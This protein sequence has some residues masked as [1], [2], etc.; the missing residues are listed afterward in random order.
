MRVHAEGMADEVK[1]AM[2]EFISGRKLA[3]LAAGDARN[4]PNRC[5]SKTPMRD[6][7]A[8]PVWNGWSPD[9]TN[10]RFHRAS[11]LS[12]SDV[13]RLT[14]KW[15]FGFPGVSSVYGQPTV[16]GGRV[17]VGV[18]T[19]Y[20]YALDAASGCVHWSFLA[21]T[22]VRNAINI[23][24]ASVA[25][26]AG[27]AGGAPAGR[28]AA[29]FGDIRGN[30]Y[31]VDAN[32][33]ELLWKVN[34]DPHPLAAITGSPTLYEGRLYV[35]VSS[36]EEAAG[37]SLNYPCCTFRGSIVALDAAT[38]RQL[39]KTYAIADP[40]K[41]SRRNS[42]GTQLWTGAGA[43]IWHAPTIDPRNRAIYV[44]TGDAY[45]E[46]AP[47]TTDAVMAIH[48]DT[49]AVLWSVQD[50][51]NDAWLVACA[52]DPTENCPKN[53]GPDYDFGASPILKTLPD[54]KRAL[55]AGQK[56]G[57]VFA[58][59]PDDRGKLLWKAALVE[60]IG[61]SEILFGGAAD[62]GTAYFA[63]DNGS[64]G[65]ARSGHR[66]A[67][68]V[69]SSAASRSAA[70]RDG[71]P[72]G[73]SGCRVRRRSGWNHPCARLRRWPRALELQHA[74][75]LHDSERH[76]RP[77]R[78]HGRPWSCGRG[79]NAIRRFG[80]RGAR[81]RNARQRVA[82]IRITVDCDSGSWIFNAKVGIQADFAAKDTGEV[83]YSS[84]ST[85]WATPVWAPG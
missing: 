41:P 58:H 54:G 14:L 55:L 82:R 17:F 72:D 70:R 19:G 6:I 59:D 31:S 33:G 20:V 8:G 4:M 42:Q 9:A 38:G 79:R 40:P 2:A 71:R 35:P 1:R 16:A 67:E 64:R 29:F 62:E 45:T 84:G 23:G 80:I 52:Q 51:E 5:T 77:G 32:T 74:P 25:A 30:V 56:S 81:Q 60:K 27:R 78:V 15:A 61:E 48:M 39:W 46:P 37:G 68:V 65:G 44:A 69:P 43:A 76:P 47:K 11:G 50:Y 85:L 10:S 22:G 24:P 21:E 73:D 12:A 7:A 28:L 49:G 57:Q 63:L 13:P 53:L 34:A 26:S 83:R 18:D 75:G 36:R 66:S 3:P